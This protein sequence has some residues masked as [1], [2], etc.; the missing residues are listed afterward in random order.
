[1]AANL[2]EKYLMIVLWTISDEKSAAT[3]SHRGFNESAWQ[4]QSCGRDGRMTV[5]ISWLLVAHL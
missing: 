3:H 4:G 1:M 2:K 5:F